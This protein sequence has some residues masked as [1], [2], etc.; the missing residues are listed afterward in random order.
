MGKPNKMQ[1]LK[2]NGVITAA[3]IPPQG[4]AGNYNDGIFVSTLV[5][6]MSDAARA[7]VTKFVA[8]AWSTVL[9][10]KALENRVAEVTDRCPWLEQD[11][12][13]P[14]DSI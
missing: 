5:T 4:T 10:Q 12:F 2:I 7:H 13:E 8:G 11:V 1:V 3:Y 6:R 9:A 14:M